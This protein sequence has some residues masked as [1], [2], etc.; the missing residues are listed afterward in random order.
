MEVWRRGHAGEKFLDHSQPSIA[1]HQL[2]C[3]SPTG[4]I[5][6]PDGAEETMQCNYASHQLTR[7]RGPVDK[8]AMVG[9]I[10]VPVESH[11]P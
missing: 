2:H 3:S 6:Q 4:R 9:P 11:G 1:M 8:R 5:A 7:L 10:C